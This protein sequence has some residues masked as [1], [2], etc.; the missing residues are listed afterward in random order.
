[1]ALSV[2]I[3]SPQTIE[4]RGIAKSE[5]NKAKVRK[6]AGKLQERAAKRFEQMGTFDGRLKANDPEY[7]VQKVLSGL[8]PRLGHRTGKLQ[9]ALYRYRCWRVT[10]LKNGYRIIL[11]DAPIKSAVPHAEYYI[12]AKTIGGKIMGVSFQWES[13][14]KSALAGAKLETQGV[15]SQR[16]VA[17]R[18]RAIRIPIRTRREQR[19]NTTEVGR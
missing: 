6:L 8:D 13:E 14:I 4:V 16:R 10:E 18:G 15:P 7:N 17:R 11:T 2:K 1:M 3:A 12:S 5:A 9:E 19:R